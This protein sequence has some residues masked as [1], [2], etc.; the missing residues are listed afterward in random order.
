M[1]IRKER[2]RRKPRRGGAERART[3][4]E[5]QEGVVLL[6]I[7]GYARL[8]S[9]HRGRRRG[10]GRGSPGVLVVAAAVVVVVGSRWLLF[11]LPP[12]PEPIAFSRA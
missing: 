8:S 10:E 4:L 1:S 9:A 11:D 5:F 6:D 3:V 7:D 12:S 2:S